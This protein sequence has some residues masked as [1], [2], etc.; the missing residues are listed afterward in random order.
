MLLVMGGGTRLVS[1]PGDTATGDRHAFRDSTPSTSASISVMTRSSIADTILTAVSRRPT[2]SEEEAKSNHHVAACE[3]E[4]RKNDT[5]MS[6]PISTTEQL[7]VEVNSQLNQ[8]SSAEPSE[9]TTEA[10]PPQHPTPPASLLPPRLHLLNE[11]LVEVSIKAAVATLANSKKTILSGTNLSDNK[12]SGQG[13]LKDDNDSEE[14]SLNNMSI[15]D[16]LIS[17]KKPSRKR[18]PQVK[19]GQSTGR[20]THEEH[21]TFLQGLASCGREWKK[22][23]SLIPT[24]SSAQIRSHAQKYFSKVQKED[25][26]S[27]S[28]RESHSPQNGASSIPTDAGVSQLLP[29][30]QQNVERILANPAVVER[31]V[32]DT[33][34]ALRVRYRQL[35]QR[36]EQQQQQRRENRR[37]RGR[38][39]EEEDD[40]DSTGACRAVGDIETRRRKRFLDEDGDTHTADSSRACS[41]GDDHS[42]VSSEV[43]ASWHPRDLENEELIALHVLGGSLPRGDSSV[44]TSA[45]QDASMGDVE[46]RAVQDTVMEECNEQQQRSSH[47]DDLQG[48]ESVSSNGS[49]AKR[50]R[51]AQE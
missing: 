51:A 18:S 23:A 15:G 38:I 22:V 14:S 30:V 32:G 26:A 43:S 11:E 47:D 41:N 33:L 4:R 5:I 12:K 25:D 46:S 39:V 20:W 6:Q 7:P 44:D 21:Q 50:A 36:L 40:D 1:R 19:A 2:C 17:N 28:A 34:Q 48:S 27:T 9:E 31:E 3:T 42:S 37:T 13:S 16:E 8:P 24:R 10:S 45:V 35:Q 49:A 29:S